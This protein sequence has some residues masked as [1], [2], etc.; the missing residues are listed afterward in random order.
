ML[1]FKNKLLVAGTVIIGVVVAVV[2]S[3]RLWIHRNSDAASATV[4]PAVEAVLSAC[5]LSRV[6]GSY[7]ESE[8]LTQ[9]KLITNLPLQARLDFYRETLLHCKLD[10]SRA[11]VFLEVVGKDVE[12]LHHSLLALRVSP[13]FKELSAGQRKDVDAW[14]DELGAIAADG[15]KSGISIPASVRTSGG[16]N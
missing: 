16:S 5:L 15:R 4:R 9:S 7:W 10:T 8:M 12:P 14:I 3:F 13:R 11:L 6:S 2:V 1:V